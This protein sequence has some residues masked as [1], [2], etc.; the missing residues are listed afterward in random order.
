MMN[1]KHIDS[2]YIL[3]LKS[4]FSNC[5]SPECNNRRHLLQLTAYCVNAS[6]PA[7]MIYSI[8]YKQVISLVFCVPAPKHSSF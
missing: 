6:Y 8:S 1:I 3:K 2:M 7:I 5:I 4:K